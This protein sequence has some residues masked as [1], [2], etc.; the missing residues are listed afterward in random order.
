ML[1]PRFALFALLP[2]LAVACGRVRPAQ[3]EEGSPGSADSRN[4]LIGRWATPSFFGSNLEYLDFREDGTVLMTDLE[5]DAVEGTYHITPGADSKGPPGR[6]P[7]AE[8]VTVQVTF[9]PPRHGGSVQSRTLTLSGSALR[10][11]NGPYGPRTFT[12]AGP[13]SD[14]HPLELPGP[15]ELHRVSGLYVALGSLLGGPG[16]AGGELIGAWET[17]ERG[18]RIRLEFRADDTVIVH[19]LSPDGQELGTNRGTYRMLDGETFDL[20]F[21]GAGQDQPARIRYVLVGDE[22]RLTAPNGNALI[23]HRAR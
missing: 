11:N 8:A 9:P 21:R 10:D 14:A 2:L 3:E 13:P 12:Y 17:E 19:I 20:M 4:Q 23:L 16:G 5:G 18:Q 6:P 1:R 15:E 22:L 7:G